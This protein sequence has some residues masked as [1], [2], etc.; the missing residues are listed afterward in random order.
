MTAHPS[1]APSQRQLRVGEELR[2]AL[3]QILNRGDLRDR[4]LHDV[5]ITV[6]EVRMSPDLRTAAAYVMPLGG[7]QVETVLA[8]LKRAAPYLRNQVAGSV[9]LKYVPQLVFRADTSFEVGA[10]I[11]RLLADER[12]QRDLRGPETATDDR[13]EDRA[14]GD[15]DDGP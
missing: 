3:S 2:H 11:D 10:R 7:A 12:V 5:S 4:D 8:A 13:V 15:S 9:R 14:P 1:K 6:T